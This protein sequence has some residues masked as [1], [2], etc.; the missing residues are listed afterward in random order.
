LAPLRPAI[1]KAVEPAHRYEVPAAGGVIVAPTSIMS[2]RHDHL[3]NLSDP[4]FYHKFARYRAQFLPHRLTIFISS[5]NY[6]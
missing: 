5:V 4:I 2:E 1:N 6:K 3:R